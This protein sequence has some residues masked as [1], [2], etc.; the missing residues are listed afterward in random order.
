MPPAPLPARA[1]LGTPSG[2]AFSALAV[3]ACLTLTVGTGVLLGVKAARPAVFL[4]ALPVQVLQ[5]LH[6]LGVIGFLLC[7]VATLHAL[8]LRKARAPGQTACRAV[9][10]IHLCLV[11]TG[12][13]AIVVGS[14]SGI[15]YL[16]WPVPLTI[17]PV[18]TLSFLA[19]SAARNVRCLSRLSGEGA[20]LLLTGLCLAPLGLI[21]RAAGS[22]VT[23]ITRSLTIEW[24]ALDTVFAGLN[25]A[26][27]GLAIVLS[28]D[29]GRVRP[30]RSGWRWGLAAFALLSTFGHHHY[31]S[32]QPL[33][34]KWAAFVA[35][36]LGL[37][38]FVRH[39][40]FARAAIMAR[41]DSAHAP[42]LGRS[43][44]VWTAFAVGSGVLLAVPQVNHLLHGTH[45]IVGH[46]MGA[47]IGV[48]VLI[49]LGAMMG[50]RRAP[51][52]AASVRRATLICNI[53]LAL[54][55][56]DFALAGVA[57]GAIRVGSSHHEYQPVVR[58]TMA[59][60]PVLGGILAGSLLW[61]LCLA[62]GTASIERA[63]THAGAKG[64]P[65]G[66]VDSPRRTLTGSTRRCR[67][68]GAFEQES[69]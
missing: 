13:G 12:G 67:P 25:T 61:L 16:S 56:L 4:G 68:A 44:A 23:D 35:S 29:A 45:A 55:V 50:A 58:W 38:S 65:R 63:L 18:A 15:E 39:V 59:P 41:G 17:L 14:G 24:H 3:A 47:V 66:R 64:P 2:F 34:L 69:P 43:A 46:A 9:A 53:A 48:D 52:R 19:W 57:K 1:T 33:S 21:E 54:I 11:V 37:I 62:L 5:P 49:V 30:L 32:A 31:A 60:L 42:A 10:A 27:Y 22:G 20:W 8:A 7:G 26:I 40:A 6:T 28:S 36:M 51:A